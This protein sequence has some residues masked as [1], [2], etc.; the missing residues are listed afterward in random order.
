[1]CVYVYTDRCSSAVGKFMC[2]CNQILYSS[3]AAKDL[4]LSLR[5]LPKPQ[6]A[7]QLVSSGL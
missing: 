6:E 2:L 1:M 5:P 7:C 4:F 3:L